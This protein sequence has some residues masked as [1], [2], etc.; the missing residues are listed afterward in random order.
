M[1]LNSINTALSALHGY[2]KGF[3]ASAGNTANIATE[4]YEPVEAVFTEAPQG[5]VE[6]TLRQSDESPPATRSGTDVT[7]ETVKNITYRAGFR[8]NAGVIKRSDEM[9]GTLL[10]LMA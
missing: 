8:A 10:D 3:A 4:G 9:L 5:G 1:V 2:R 6:V 7:D